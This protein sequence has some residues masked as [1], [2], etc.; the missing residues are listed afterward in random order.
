[1]DNYLV[2]RKMKKLG[3]LFEKYKKT[4]KAPQGSVK[5]ECVRVIKE[6]SGFDVDLEQMDYKVGTRTL[7]LSIPSILKNELKFHY[8]KILLQLRE[9][10]GE[11][12]APKFII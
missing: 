6:V 9:D 2:P 4:I 1:M 10:L 5:K 8:E 12:V 11:D 7:Y 3:D